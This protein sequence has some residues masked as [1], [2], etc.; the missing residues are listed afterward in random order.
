MNELE[1][2][3]GELLDQ[4][5]IVQERHEK[6][7]TSGNKSAEADVRAALGEI[8]KLVTPYR[9]ISVEAVKSMKKK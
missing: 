8:K 5:K 4:M 2:V 9:K 3:Y 1:K 6:F 7:V